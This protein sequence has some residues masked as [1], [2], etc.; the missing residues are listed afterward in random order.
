MRCMAKYATSSDTTKSPI[1]DTSAIMRITLDAVDLPPTFPIQQ[2]SSVLDYDVTEIAG[3]PFVVPIKSV[4][5]LRTG[6]MLNKNDIEFRFYKKFGAEATIKIG[7]A[8]PEDKEQPA[9]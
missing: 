8:L 2:A 1:P 6:R 3:S 9:K 5:R 4:M 7:E